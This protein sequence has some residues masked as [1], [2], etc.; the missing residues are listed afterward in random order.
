MENLTEYN[1]QKIPIPDTLFTV[2]R[3]LFLKYDVIIMIQHDMTH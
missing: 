1:L 3:F 2:I